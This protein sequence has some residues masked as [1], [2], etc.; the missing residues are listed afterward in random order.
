MSLTVS[1]SHFVQKRLH[2]ARPPGSSWCHGTASVSD[3]SRQKEK[4]VNPPL[5]FPHKWWGP[6]RMRPARREVLQT[7]TMTARPP[8][9][10]CTDTS[11]SKCRYELNE[12][13]IFDVRGGTLSAGGAPRTP[14]TSGRL[15]CDISH[16]SWLKRR[17]WL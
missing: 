16:V 8:S 4:K 9:F 5:R 2:K 13:L 10:A 6:L 12:C 17:H 3:D 1:C 7:T 11:S 15:L 14:L